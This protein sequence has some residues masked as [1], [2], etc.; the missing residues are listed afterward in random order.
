MLESRSTSNSGILRPELEKTWNQNKCL[1]SCKLKSYKFPGATEA[2]THG[3]LEEFSS[4]Q[5]LETKKEE[6]V[7]RNNKNYDKEKK[8]LKEEQKNIIK[9]I[10]SQAVIKIASMN[11]E[12]ARITWE[13]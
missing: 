12:K 13:I 10:R 2:S 5:K 9:E 4:Q 8:E 11:T 3:A 7:R 1:K 6:A